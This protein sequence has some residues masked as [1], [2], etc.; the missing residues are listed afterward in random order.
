M[1]RIVT[2]KD[3]GLTIERK[4]HTLFKWFLASYLFGKRIQQG[5]AWKTWQVFMEKGIDTPQ[6]I[7]AQSWQQL[8]GLL[9]EGHYRRYDESTA[10]NL[11]DMSRALLRDYH[12]NLLNMY[13]GC[14]DEKEFVKRLQKF[15][16]VGPKTAEIFMREA[17]PVLLRTV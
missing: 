4:E 11:L 10:H 1:K 16:G 12:G 5:V 15:K 7:A 17:R 8:V 9:G 3:L 6:K 13:D 2:A 14:S